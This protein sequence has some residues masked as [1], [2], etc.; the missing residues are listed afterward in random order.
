MRSDIDITTAS[1]AEDFETGRALFREYAADLG[2]DLSSGGRLAEEIDRLPGPYAEPQGTL[3]IARVGGVAAGALGLQPVPADARVEGIG[4][5]CF[6]ELKRLFVRP[7]YRRSGIGRA[8][9]VCAE[10][11]ARR[12]GY[13]SLVLTTSAEMMPLAQPLYEQL[14]YESATPY[15]TDMTWPT[16]IWL[17]KAL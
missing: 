6:G 14:G 7:E 17:R 3:L 8:L 10:E 15:R 9:M 4:A 11:E 1:T 5:E 12:R 2:W 13:R 16:L